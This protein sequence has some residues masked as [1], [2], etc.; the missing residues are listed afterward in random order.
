MPK[1]RA[2]IAIELEAEDIETVQE[3]VLE[4]VRSGIRQ[5]CMIELAQG[6]KTSHDT[7]EAMMDYQHLMASLKDDTQKH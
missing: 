2:R 1:F 7:D 6:I 3:I 4:Y 5:E